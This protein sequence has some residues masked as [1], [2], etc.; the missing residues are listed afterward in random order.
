VEV[1]VVRPEEHEAAGAVVLAAYRALPGAHLS[2]DY[3]AELVDV[4]RRAREA[5]V[6]VAVA[7]RRLRRRPMVA[8]EPPG[9]ADGQGLVGCATF[10]PDASSPWA[11]LLEKGEAGI[12]MLAVMP[13]SQGQGIGRALVD[14]CVARARSLGREALMLHTTPWMTAAQHLYASAGFVRFSERDWTPVPDVPLLA[15]RLDLD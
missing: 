13:G 11:E 9:G 7:P 1:R 4:A 14:S 2:D 8:A 10:V 6:L 5:D 12:R 15:Y 3:A